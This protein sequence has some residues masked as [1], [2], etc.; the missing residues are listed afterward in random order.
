[1][2]ETEAMERCVRDSAV[3]SFWTN[4]VAGVPR[5]PK[6]SSPSEMSRFDACILTN[7]AEEVV[8]IDQSFT[9]R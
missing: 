3:G 4:V 5:D 8:S 6:R 7:D 1:M 2:F 9:G